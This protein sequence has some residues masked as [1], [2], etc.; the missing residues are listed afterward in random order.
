MIYELCSNI[1][2]FERA[3]QPLQSFTTTISHP[4]DII[5]TLSFRV[6]KMDQV[7]H[8]LHMSGCWTE[9]F[10]SFPSDRFL[11]SSI[12]MHSQH[13]A[14]FN[15]AVGFLDQQS[16]G[17][18]TPLSYLLLMRRNLSPLTQLNC[19]LPGCAMINVVSW[20]VERGLLREKERILLCVHMNKGANFQ[21]RELSFIP[22]KPGGGSPGFLFDH[23]LSGAHV[24]LKG[25]KWCFAGLCTLLALFEC[26]ISKLFIFSFVHVEKD[27]TLSFSSSSSFFILLHVRLGRWCEDWN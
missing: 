1:P 13:F 7:S 20:S 15:V 11:T 25:K 16:Q 14:S 2:A 9:S 21:V 17:S 18:G 24:I 10:L 19:G 4:L 3:Y 27:L 22:L 12:L 5:L 23:C 8:S 26:M 6:L